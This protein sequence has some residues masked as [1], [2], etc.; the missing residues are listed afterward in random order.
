MLGT[1]KPETRFLRDLDV[2]IH[3]QGFASE[4]VTED[5]SAH[6]PAKEP[7]CFNIGLLHTCANSDPRGKYAPCSIAGLLSKGY[8]YWCWDTN[9]SA[10]TPM[11]SR[12]TSFSQATCRAG[13]AAKAKSAKKAVCS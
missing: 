3:G 13:T 1:E 10:R 8:D 6:Y 11:M 2:A 4:A 9:T 5:L 7:G 12:R